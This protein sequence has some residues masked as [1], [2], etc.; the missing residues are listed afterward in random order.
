[1]IL[2]S[3]MAVACGQDGKPGRDGDRGPAGRD[4]ID[5]K[6]VRAT[7]C[8]GTLKFGDFAGMEVK[9][10]AQETSAG[11]TFSTGVFVLGTYTQSSSQAWASESEN[12]LNAFVY[13]PIDQVDWMTMELNKDTKVVTI[14]FLGVTKE[15]HEFTS[16]ECNSYSY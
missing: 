10:A 14:K 9:Y 11:D 7:T 12:G 15:T 6:I 4:G 3:L 2:V 1:M 16:S 8:E 13:I 5:N